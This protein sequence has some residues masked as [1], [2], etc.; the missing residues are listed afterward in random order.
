MLSH[1]LRLGS[2]LVPA[3]Y[4][5]DDIVERPPHGFCDV[6]INPANEALVGTRLPYFPMQV[7]PP[8][9]LQNSRWCGMEAGSGMFYAQQVVDG[10]VHAL[11]GP[12][13]KEACLQLAEVSPG[14]R[15]PTGKAVTTPALGGLSKF[16]SHIVHTAPPCAE[17]LWCEGLPEVPLPFMSKRLQPR[18]SSRGPSTAMT[19]KPAL[20][21]AGRRSRTG[22]R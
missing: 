14:I 3:R 1:V 15:C 9:E 16:F 8:P 18:V 11:G 6:L 2:E 13:L 7:E 17:D 5:T 21:A 19:G 4:L 10:R 20:Q 12:H 22:V